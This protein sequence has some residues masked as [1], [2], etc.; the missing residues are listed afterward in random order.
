MPAAWPAF[1]W[2]LKETAMKISNT[3]G[4]LKPAGALALALIL[5]ACGGGG[6]GGDTAPEDKKA[7]LSVSKPGELAAYVQERLRTLERQGRLGYGGVYGGDGVPS[8]DVVTPVAGVAAPPPRSSTLVQ[9]Q[10]VDEADIIQTDGNTLYT[11]QPKSGAPGAV[12]NIYA[13]GSDGRANAV[14]TLPLDTDGARAVQDPGM[15]ASTDQR[16]LAVISQNWTLVAQPDACPNCPTGLNIVA[17]QWG[18]SSVNVQRVD[19]SDPAKARAGERISI[20]GYLVDS[21]RIGDK[22]YVVTSHHPAL[23][24]LMLPATATAA[25]REASIASLTAADLLPR[26]RR[27]G[28]AGEPLLADTDCFLQGANASTSVQITTV[29]IFDLAS[30]SLARS[31][32]CFVG[33][34]EALYMTSQSLYL[35]TTTGLVG[36]DAINP[37]VGLNTD[38]HKFALQ[39][40]SV[41][42]RGSGQVKGHLGWDRERKSLRLSEHNGDLRVLSYTGPFGWWGPQDPS[43]PPT[44]PP[45]PATLTVLRESSNSLQTVSTL[46]NSNRPAA[47]GKPGEQ[48]YAV[49]FVGDRAYVVTFR[50]IDPLYV[51]DLSNP[52]DPKT[53]GEL[54][55]AGFSDYLFPLANNLLLGVG[56]DADSRGVATGVKLALF[57]V[58]NPA[59]P[60]QKASITLGTSG[61]SSAL[62]Y[63]RHGL[64]MMVLGNTAR[65]ALPVNLA[66]TT[67]ADWQHGL[68]RVDIN[69]Q[70]GTMNAKPLIAATNNVAYAP[71]WLE[72]AAQIGDKVYFLNNG[73]LSTHD[74]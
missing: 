3:H 62:D 47:I 65:V 22:L 58:G 49:R 50:R 61:S 2:R 11:L 54:E 6:G 17:P 45:S 42:Y 63:S 64:N 31:S 38:L 66:N 30:S 8:V 18:R 41:T 39:N 59:A 7:A 68:Q 60:A 12:L 14:A 24:V 70:A 33:G 16:A 67:F 53:V 55:V 35:A 9:E 1:F 73:E 25:Q 37:A 40:G 20:D 44:T 46:P 74:W 34:A 28:G 26:M 36:G 4:P 43:S 21:R 15:V 52:A 10:G 19:V 56:K 32:R 57:D 29:T 71:L 48:V 23:P 51:L 69:T 5:A 13:R 72:R 27:N